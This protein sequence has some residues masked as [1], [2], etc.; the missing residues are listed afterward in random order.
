M[1]SHRVYLDLDRSRKDFIDN[2]GLMDDGDEKGSVTDE[3]ENCVK[4]LDNLLNLLQEGQRLM[5][6]VWYTLVIYYVE[7][8]VNLILFSHVLKLLFIRL[9]NCRMKLECDTKQESL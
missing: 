3:Q 2:D 8:I 7:R 5:D 1:R 9:P 6:M 4:A